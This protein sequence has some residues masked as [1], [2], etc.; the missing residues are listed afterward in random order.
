MVVSVLGEVLKAKGLSRRAVA[1]RAGIAPNQVGNLC[2]AHHSEMP[3]VSLTT[4]SRVCMVLNIEITD[5]L[6]LQPK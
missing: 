4:L 2:R 3:T 6:K 1:R 5:V